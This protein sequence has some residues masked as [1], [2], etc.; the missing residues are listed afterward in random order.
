M[1]RLAS[2]TPARQGQY[3]RWGWV[4]VRGTRGEE[5]EIKIEV[6]QAGLWLFV[7]SPSGWCQAVGISQD[8][9]HKCHKTGRKRKP[10]QEK[11]KSEPGHPAA[12]TKMGP[13]CVHTQSTV[14]NQQEVPSFEARRGQQ[15]WAQCWTHKTRIIHVVYSTSNNELGHTKTLI[16][17]W[18]LLINGTP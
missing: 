8:N 15:S 12:N 4:K 2:L 10:Y 13:R 17:N 18:I 11:R 14:G 1:C 6:A 7:F 3:C 16:K 9:R 5:I